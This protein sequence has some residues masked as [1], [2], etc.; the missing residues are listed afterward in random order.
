M[1]VVKRWDHYRLCLVFGHFAQ[2][3]ILFFGYYKIKSK[4]SWALIEFYKIMKENQRLLFCFECFCLC[5]PYLRVLI[6]FLRFLMFFL[7]CF[8]GTFVLF[9]FGLNISNGWFFLFSLLVVPPCFSFLLSLNFRLSGAILLYFSSS[10]LYFLVFLKVL[11]SLSKTKLWG[12]ASGSD[13]ISLL[14]LISSELSSW[15][16]TLSS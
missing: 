2:S 12:L 3:K 10:I 5:W 11:I 16:L 15:L 1:D 6:L 9:F 4:S 7:S 8:I 14:N 13:S